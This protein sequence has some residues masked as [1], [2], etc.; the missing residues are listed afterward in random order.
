[1][2]AI[3]ITSPQ[4]RFQIAGDRLNAQTQRLRVYAASGGE[5]T[6]VTW[7]QAIA[8]WQRDPDFGQGLTQALAAI[9]FAAFF[10]ETP[11]ITPHTLPQAWECVAVEAP[12]LAQVSPDPTPFRQYL[13][14][15]ATEAIA[16]F[17]N[18]GGDALLVVPQPQGPVQVYPH[19]ATFLRSGPPTQIQALWQQLGITVQHH[20]ANRSNR[21]LWVSTSGLGVYWLHIRLDDSPKYYTHLPYKTWR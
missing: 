1:M 16:T 17:P 14:Q 21:P 2:A 10:W 12:A 9:P 5:P 8:L 18:L 15:D 13:A 6:P 19:L 3:S 20:L 4:G 11:P 7:Q